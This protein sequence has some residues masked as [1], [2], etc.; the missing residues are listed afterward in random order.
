MTHDEL[1]EA[2]PLYALG[3]LDRPERQVLEAHLLSGCSECHAALKE[4]QTIAS[5]L[6][7]GLEPIAPPRRLKSQIMAARTPTVATDG[8]GRQTAKPSL[9]PG[10]WMNHLFPPIAPVRSWPL[11]LAVGLVGVL[12]LAGAGFF[13]WSYYLQASQES[14]RR[15]ASDAAMQSAA[16]RVAS[17]EQENRKLQELQ[18][19]AR[20]TAQQQ[21]VELTALK[22][23]LAQREA[24]VEDLKSQVEQRDT[25]VA[26]LARRQDE[27]AVLFRSPSAKMVTL[28]GSD[29]AKDAAALLIYEPRSLKAWLYAY[30]LPDLPPGSIYQFWAIDQASVSAGMFGIDLGQKG[31]LM[32]KKLPALSPSTKFAVSVEPVGG[33]T[34]PTGA[35]YLLGQL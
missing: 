34:E 4:H 9:E 31:R 18:A 3:A 16:I 7:F 5:I 25:A 2:V 13:A 30:N 11:K 17:L 29:L 27:V 23:S 21:A 32:I 24:E 33:R 35:I 14:L 20:D 28:T 22:E 19:Q 6:P 26:R 8:N 12:L 1:Q 15:A 10:D